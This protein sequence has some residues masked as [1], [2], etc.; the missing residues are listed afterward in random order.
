MLPIQGVRRGY[1]NRSIQSFPQ[2]NAGLPVV[3]NDVPP[4]EPGNSHWHAQ[5]LSE[6]SPTWGL[7]SGVVPTG[8]TDRG[9]RHSQTDPAVNQ[10]RLG[11][12]EQEICVD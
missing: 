9:Q 2:L 5:E 6:S 11:E 7:N 4:N 10:P 3:H 12:E 1:A 8:D